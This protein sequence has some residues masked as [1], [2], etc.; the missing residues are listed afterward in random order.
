LQDLGL[1]AAIA[2]LGDHLSESHPEWRF[3]VDVDDVTLA[4][5]PP[6]D[7]ELAA[8]RVIQEATANALAHSGGHCLQ[9]G[10]LVATDTIDLRATDDGHGF[11]D[12]DAREARR[13]GHFG[14]DAMRERAA[15]V[16]A[17]VLVTHGPPG[18][19]VQFLWERR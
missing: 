11:H 15:A 10:G 4:D 3:T 18:A 17:R 1:A 6:G 2:D 9:I 7:V 16:D 14:L 13:A 8:F 5:R 19:S 12:D